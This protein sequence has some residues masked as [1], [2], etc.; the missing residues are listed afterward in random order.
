MMRKDALPVC[1][2]RR[3]QISRK[4]I[5]DLTK[6]VSNYGARGLAWIKVND[7]ASG[8]EGLQSPILK[9]MPEAT[10]AALVE[11]LQLEDGDIVSLVL[12][13]GRL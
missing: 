9:F 8:V 6:Y 5:D 10:V 3:R 11:R 7:K 12:I 1:A 13:S 2:S 4:E